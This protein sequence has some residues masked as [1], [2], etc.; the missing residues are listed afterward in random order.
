MR[1]NNVTGANVLATGSFT[2]FLARR[3]GI[4]LANLQSNFY[5]G[6]IDNSSPLPITL[7]Y[8][9]AQETDHGIVL[10]WATS[11]EK[12][13]DHFE[14]ER[15][16]SDLVFTPISSIP[17]NGG[18]DITTHYSFLDTTPTEGKNY[19][20]LKSVDLDNT[21]EYSTVIVS[22]WAER[23]NGIYLYPNPVTDH[24]FTV[25]LN[26]AMSSPAT[27]TVT[28]ARGYV[29]HTTSLTS[30]GASVTLPDSLAPGIYFVK[31]SARNGHK[32]IRIVVDR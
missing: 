16:T 17:G 29:V 1:L 4:T 8:F 9:N 6:S 21:L 14:L 23:S 5:I 19:Y 32:T 20:R 28:E 18:L 22:D 7:L 13:F 31:I 15:A 27:L 30:S 12:N 24:S 26:D 3:T 10:D 11:M 2:D 25:N